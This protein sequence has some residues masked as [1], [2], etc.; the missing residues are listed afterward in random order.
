MSKSNENKSRTLGMP[1][2]TACNR[3]RKN[4][5]FH[6]LQKLKENIC[7]KCGVSITTVND[8]SIEHKK[9]WE[10]RSAELFWD[11]ENIT[12]S[13]LRCNTPHKQG[14][15]SNRIERPEGFN[16][17]YSCRAM[18]PVDEFYKDALRKT[19]LANLCIQCKT[20]QNESRDRTK[21]I[22]EPIV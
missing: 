5:L 6:L 10:S 1:F 17:C 11:L 14:G 8:L 16:W 9:P 20:V 18:K 19:G 7:F 2:G 4:I 12:F 3:L 15:G 21:K 22:F 13:H